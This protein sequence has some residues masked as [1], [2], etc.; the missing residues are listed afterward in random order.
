MMRIIAFSKENHQQ[1]YV[2]GGLSFLICEVI[3]GDK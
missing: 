1:A 2:A 3:L